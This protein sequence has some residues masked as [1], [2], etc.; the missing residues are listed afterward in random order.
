MLLSILHHEK[1]IMEGSRKNKPEIM[2][3]Y[4]STK[5]G[6]DVMHQMVH[7]YSCKCQTKRRPMVLWYNIM[8][9]HST[10]SRI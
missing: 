9:V 5:G 3:Y 8:D 7:N 10:A 6:I 2:T 4:N 1:S